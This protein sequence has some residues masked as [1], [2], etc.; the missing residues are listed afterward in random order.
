MSRGLTRGVLR[1]V[2]I[3]YVAFVLVH[4]PA[5]QA[6][7][8]PAPDPTQAAI[9]SLSP[10][11]QAVLSRLSALSDLP[12]GEWRFHAGDLPHA[13]SPEV[14]DSKWELRKGESIAPPESVWFRRWVEVPKTLGGYDLTGSQIW[15]QFQADVNGP[16]TTI[17]YVDGRRVAMGEELEPVVLFDNSKPG[18]KVLIAVKLLQTVDQKRVHPEIIRIFQPSSRPSPSDMREEFV[19]AA[20]LIPSLAS[21]PAAEKAI[22]EKAMG[23]VDLAA[24]DAANQN[25]F[26]ASLRKSQDLLQPIQPTLRKATYHLTGN[27]HIDAAWIWPWT[28]TVDSV[29][30]TWGT[31]LQLMNE[32]PMYTFTQSAAQYNVWM[33]EKYPQ[34]NDAIKRRIQE[35]RWEIVGG[36]WI[37]PDLNMPDGESLVRQILIGKRTYKQ[38]YGVDVRIGWNPDSFGYNW[39]LPQIYKRAGID[40]FVTQKMVWNDT[41]QLPLKLFWWESPDGSKVLTYFPHGYDNA[42]FNPSRLA[43]DMMTAR[44]RATGLPE[45]MDLYGVGDHGGGATRAVLDDG[46][47]W[48]G[49][50]K[51]TPKMQFGLAQTFFHDV[52]GKLDSDSP[53]WNYAALAAGKGQLGAPSNDRIK[54]PTWNDE[55][56][57]EYHRGVQTTQANHKRNMRESEEW[58]LNAEKYA[59]LAWLNGSAYPHA[60]LNDAWKKVLF[61]QFHDLAAGS[62][63]GVIYKDAQKDYD[64]VRRS[65]NEVSAA[66]VHTVQAEIDTRGDAGVPVVIFNPLAWNRSGVVSVEVEMPAAIPQ[67]VSVLDAHQRV[68][69]SLRVGQDTRTNTVRLLVQAKDVPSFGYQVVRVVP[70]R[71]DAPT[72]LKANGLELENSFLRVVVNAHTG[73]I[74]SLYDK[75]SHF[76]TLASGGCG[77]ELIA[78][79]DVPK[80]Y[81]AWNIDANFDQVFTKLEQADSVERVESNSL[82]AVIRVSRHWQA[83]KFVQ[84]IVLYNGS[85][86]VEVVNDID[87]HEEHILLKAAF[88]LAASGKQATYEIPYGSIQRPTT[89]DNS[90]ESAKFEVPA[91]RW[92]DAGNE[93]HGF[94]LINESKYGYDDKGNVL[95]LSL[96]R[97]PTWPDPDADRGHH[98]FSYALYPHAGTWKQALT[99]RHGYEFNYKLQA[100]QVESH[101]GVL[102]SEH[103]FIQ[104]DAQNVVLTAL[105]KSEDSDGLI[106]RFYEWAGQNGNV[107]LSVPEGVVSATATNLMEQSEGAPLAVVAGESPSLQ[108]IQLQVHPY[109]IISVRLDYKHPA[110]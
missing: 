18:D 69:P 3:L 87:W 73:C 21:N 102:P 5:A 78:F 62:G 34:I 80:D 74:T 57:F 93:A 85:D 17:I 76:E 25:S 96:L 49:A 58:M 50:D 82:R 110:Q 19:S 88:P 83:S 97:S 33:A 38:L 101:T 31:A 84:D 98:H 39:Q 7:T 22:L 6:Q 53:T 60:E 94:S 43:A 28:E 107:K 100:T 91:L 63:I 66:A 68:L 86:Q 95:R 103:S 106:L 51:I 70:G 14:D 109:E 16:M 37:E 61:N 105:K 104:V 15:F 29:R 23:A 12:P 92:A 40:Y 4:A 65:T 48:S 72:D 71:R 77:N 64:E 2:V 108:A 46:V 20:L 8:P 13:E 1:S 89:R 45:M 26:D 24:L 36:M 10:T 42:D 90:W 55:L 75:K 30:H 99:V 56:Y 35:G 44:E 59:S 81:D 52:E 67:D 32:Y 79:K 47:H 9:D 54:I 11:S 41:N 27:S